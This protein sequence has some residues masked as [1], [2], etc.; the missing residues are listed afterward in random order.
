MNHWSKILSPAEIEAHHALTASIDLDFATGDRKWWQS[1]TA[2]EL[3]AE[4]NGS[5]NCNCGT[6]YQLARSYLA[7][8]EA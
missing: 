5:W 1:R 4:M 7:I 6:T 8:L 2:N 3:R